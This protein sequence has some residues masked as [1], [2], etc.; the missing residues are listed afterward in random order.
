MGRLLSFPET[1]RRGHISL[2]RG[3]QHDKSPGSGHRCPAM[4]KIHANYAG[5][6]IRLNSNVIRSANIA[7]IFVYG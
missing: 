6:Y 1:T 3:G 2:H 5:K 7:E 4:E